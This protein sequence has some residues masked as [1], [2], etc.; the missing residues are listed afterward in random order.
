M[1]LC[2]GGDVGVFNHGENV[3]KML[4]MAAAGMPVLA[5]LKAATAGNA[6]SFGLANRQPRRAGPAR[7][8]RGSR[9][10]PA[11]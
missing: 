7:R 2:V 11:A 1:K 9:R 10:R 4:L 3:R 6:P 5:V 8:P